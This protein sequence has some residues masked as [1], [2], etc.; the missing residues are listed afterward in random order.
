MEIFIALA[1]LA[2]IVRIA[3][4]FLCPNV[5]NFLS[6]HGYDSGNNYSTRPLDLDRK[7]SPVESEYVVGPFKKHDPTYSTWFGSDDN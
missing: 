4:V 7:V 1:I 3:L 5:D 6:G 2:L